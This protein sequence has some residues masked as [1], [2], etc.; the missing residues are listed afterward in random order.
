VKIAGDPI[1]KRESDII[2]QGLTNQ[3]NRVGNPNDRIVHLDSIDALRVKLERTLTGADPFRASIQD[4]PLAP[5]Q[6]TGHV[7]KLTGATDVQSGSMR[8]GA[9]GNLH[10]T[11]FASDRGSNIC[12]FFCCR[13]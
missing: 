13:Y 1:L 3:A 10:K 11:V 2:L 8:S 7:E 12:R 9:T 4:P 5:N 6:L